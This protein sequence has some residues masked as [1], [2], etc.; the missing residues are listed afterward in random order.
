MLE[1]LGQAPLLFDC[2]NAVVNLLLPQE[3]LEQALRSLH[4]NLV[5]AAIL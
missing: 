5:E 3:N 2:K 4:R 1:S